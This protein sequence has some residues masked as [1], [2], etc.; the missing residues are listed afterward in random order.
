MIRDIMKDRFFL[1]QKAE[2]ATKEDKEIGDGLKET[3]DFYYHVQRQCVGMAANMIGKRKAIIAIIDHDRSVLMYNPVVIAQ[4]PKVIKVEE[5]CLSLTGV[6]PAVRSEM[7]KIT[8]LD[9]HFKKKTKTYR[10]FT[11]QVIQ[12]ELDHLNGIL[13]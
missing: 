10:G 12:H 9:E 7:I 6:R 2:E 11:A 1:S 3:L 13:I 5:G 8:Y 4:S